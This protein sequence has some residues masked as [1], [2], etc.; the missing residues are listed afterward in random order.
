MRMGTVSRINVE[1]PEEIHRLV[2]AAAALA[3]QT[4]AEWI[5]QALEAYAREVIRTAG[6]SEPED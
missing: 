6:Q 1:I 4:Q 2:R 5:P 3:G